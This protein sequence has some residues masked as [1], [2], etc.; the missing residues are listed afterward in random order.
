MVIGVAVDVHDTGSVPE[1]RTPAAPVLMRSVGV[2]D[3]PAALHLRIAQFAAAAAGHLALVEWQVHM[4]RR[5][6][7]QVVDLEWAVAS[8]KVAGRKSIGTAACGPQI[9]A[10][11]EH[12]DFV[13]CRNMAS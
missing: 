1:R 10:P 11:E 4:F 6:A 9:F 8:G 12:R 13:T 2:K 5:I 3:E 7:V